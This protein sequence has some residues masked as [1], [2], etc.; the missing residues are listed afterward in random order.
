MDEVLDRLVDTA[1]EKFTVQTPRDRRFLIGIG[2]IPG[3]GKTTLSKRLT[4]A[5]NARH[6]AQFPGSPPV[7]IF[8]PMD[9]FHYTRAQLDAMPDPATAHARRGAEFTFDGERFHQLVRRLHAPLTAATPTIYA[10][11]FDHAAKDPK[12]DDIAVEPTHRIV[13]L[14]GNC[15]SLP[16]FPF[17]PPLPS[18]PPRH[19]NQT[20]NP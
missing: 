17:N 11:S 15:A 19:P 8:V 4:A 10:P 12:E 5:L 7:A 13:V 1:W 2:G 16:V 9:G 6:A 14:E 20:F 18:P 3:S